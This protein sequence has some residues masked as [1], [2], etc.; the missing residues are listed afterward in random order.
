MHYIK[1]IMHHKIKTTTQVILT[2]VML[3]FQALENIYLGVFSATAQS[4]FFFF[5]VFTVKYISTD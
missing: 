4:F 2:A 5:A 3:Q 1:H